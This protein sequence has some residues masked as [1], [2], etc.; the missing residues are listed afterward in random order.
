MQ[1]CLKYVFTAVVIAVAIV[2]G[3]VVKL[4]TIPNNLDI[5]P[6]DNVF[7]VAQLTEEQK[8][9]YI[10]DGAVIVRSLLPMDQAMLLRSAAEKAVS[11]SYSV[12][13][14]FVSNRYS[15]VAFDV[16]RTDQFY[17]SLVL[18]NLPK[19]AAQIMTDQNSEEN[20]GSFKI[21]LLRDAYFSYKSGGKGC[22]WHVDDMGF[23]PTKED[24]S[25]LT[26]WIAL[27][28][29]SVDDGGGLAVANMSLSQDW[30]SHCRSVIRSKGTCDMESKSPDCHAKLEAI[31]MQWDMKPGD[32]ILWD[33][34]TFHRTVPSTI[35]SIEVGELVPQKLARYSVRY[36]PSTAR[37]FGS[38]HQSVQQDAY[39][40]SP[41]YP[42]VWPT[43]LDY[44]TEAL[45]QGLDGDLTLRNVIGFLFSF[46]KRQ[47]KEALRFTS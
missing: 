41:Y 2:V 1:A 42:Q 26:M 19:I 43:L 5:K 14:L 47:L 16:W 27:D 10:R 30:V 22:G 17:A 38:V 37:A 40:D 45:R 18:H 39:L 13:D 34:W 4:S 36:V 29:M 12:L 44:E 35:S 31:Q 32:A 21:R 20:E 28:K 9:S 33:R 7:I 25:G 24:T 8:E 11:K 6:V 3:L 23:W 46:T 15:K